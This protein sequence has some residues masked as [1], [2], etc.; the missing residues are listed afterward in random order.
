MQNPTV[1][2]IIDAY[3]FDAEKIRKIT[4]PESVKSH[5][6]HFLKHFGALTIEEMSVGTRMRAV[7][8]EEHRMSQ[9]GVC[10]STVNREGRNWRAALAFAFR[11]EMISA[12][13][14]K[15]WPIPKARREHVD[16]DRNVIWFSKTQ[17]RKTKKRRQDQPIHADLRVV[18]EDAIAHMAPGCDFIIQFRGKSV[19]DVRT[20]YQAMLRRIGIGGV[21][22]HDLRRTVAQTVRDETDDLGMAARLIGDTE[23]TTGSTYARPKISANWEAMEV[24]AAK[25]RRPT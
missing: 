6:K 8:Y 3:V 20:A 13:H 21:V 7:A 22:I 5:F 17:K 1:R 25:M 14:K 4:K 2:E 19:K 18:L 15:Y 10:A 11:E 24:M 16:F 12:A 9:D 23:I